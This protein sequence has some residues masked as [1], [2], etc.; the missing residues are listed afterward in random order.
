MTGLP[1]PRRRRALGCGIAATVVALVGIVPTA[2]V[3]VLASTIDPNY[4][5]LLFVTLP[6]AVFFGAVALVLGI[7][8][9]VLA[10]ADRGGYAWPIVG[11][12]LGVVQLLPAAAFLG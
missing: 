6:I 3:F 10:R 9:I 1:P 4:G 11:V 7:I 12:V 8:G 2:I 5:W